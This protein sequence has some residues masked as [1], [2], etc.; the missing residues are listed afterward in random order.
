MD[1]K[2]RNYLD[3]IARYYIVLLSAEEPKQEDL[4][5]EFAYGW[6]SLYLQR[7][8]NSLCGL[9]L[10]YENKYIPHNDVTEL[11]EFNYEKHKYIPSYKYTRAEAVPKVKQ[12]N[13]YL[14]KKIRPII[15]VILEMDKEAV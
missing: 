1:A 5:A 9:D 14:M 11:I 3:E 12:V 6:Y 15:S 4:N 7:L 2:E 13:D 8:T 10:L